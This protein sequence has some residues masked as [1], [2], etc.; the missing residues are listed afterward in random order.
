MVQ[1]RVDDKLFGLRLRD[2]ADVLRFARVQLQTRRTTDPGLGANA[3]LVLVKLH[4]KGVN[5]L[6]IQSEHGSTL[7]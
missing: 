4:D 1:H 3:L 5:L 6:P 7:S 2:V